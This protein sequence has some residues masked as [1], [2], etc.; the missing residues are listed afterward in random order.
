MS[1]N[2]DIINLVSSRQYKSISNIEILN[3]LSTMKDLN[4]DYKLNL[5]TK[6]KLSRTF[7]IFMSKEDMTKNFINP[8]K[9]LIK[10]RKQPIL[11]PI[12]TLTKNQIFPNIFS[13]YSL[14]SL[15]PDSKRTK[16][17][18]GCTEYLIMKFTLQDNLFI[19]IESKSSYRYFL[20]KH[21]PKSIQPEKILLSLDD[22]EYLISA[23]EC[24]HK[25]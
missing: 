13:Y 3:S 22:A 9:E 23:F 12:I 19:H 2:Q 24:L 4:Y 8:M 14:N 11:D 10:R 20:F 5:Q 18:L 7:D 6:D 15:L 25:S 17:M 1:N 21:R 16:A